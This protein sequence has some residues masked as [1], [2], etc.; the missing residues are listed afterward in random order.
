M[1]S[2]SMP[3]SIHR[4]VT[5]PPDDYQSFCAS[6]SFVDDDSQFSL[7]TCCHSFLTEKEGRKL[8]T[9]SSDDL[10]EKLTARCQIAN[11][12]IS[13]PTTFQ[14][15]A[16]A[17]RDVLLDFDNPR[18]HIVQVYDYMWSSVMYL[19]NSSR[20]AK[21]RFQE[22]RMGSSIVLTYGLPNFQGW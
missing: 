19:E 6:G 2:S 10:R 8:Q 12:G 22:L 3:F 17:A 4:A 21:L 7:L 15:K 11:Y 5:L 1:C 14:T 13:N 16:I 9:M 20:G 18:L